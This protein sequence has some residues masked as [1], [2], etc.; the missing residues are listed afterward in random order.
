V[1]TPAF[2]HRPR[3][4]ICL[5]TTLAVLLDHIVSADEDRLRHCQAKRLG[6]FEVDDQLECCRLPDGQVSRPCAFQDPSDVNGGLTKRIRL[7]SR[8]DIRPPAVA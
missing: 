4:E 7:V 6:G 5:R 1:F 8:I 2:S 3:C